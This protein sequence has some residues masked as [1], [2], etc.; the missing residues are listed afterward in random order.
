[1]AQ[2]L[3]DKDVENKTVQDI[4][5]LLSRMNESMKDGDALKKALEE[6]LKSIERNDRQSA[7]EELEKVAQSLE[8]MQSIAENEPQLKNLQKELSRLNDELSGQNGEMSSSEISD[9]D[10]S[11]TGN[12]EKG[13]ESIS[14]GEQGKGGESGSSGNVEETGGMEKKFQKGSSNEKRPADFGVGSTNEEV[15]NKQQEKSPDYVL[16]RQKDKESNWKGIYEK[17]YDSKREAIDS[18]QTK[19]K[20][21]VT[22]TRGVTG[23]EELRGGIPK[24]ERHDADDK[25]VYSSYKGRAE[26]AISREKIPK[27]YKSMVRNYFKEIDPSK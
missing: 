22:G 12:R 6:A 4:Q 5:S 23:S 3:K 24:A 20:S 16:N 11:S 7:S 26:E 9:N 1:M 19:V 27:E 18:A 8:K 25:A 21:Q 2:K 17:I 15:K 10:G 14:Q 13:D